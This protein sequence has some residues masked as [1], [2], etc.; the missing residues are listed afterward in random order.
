MEFG[1]ASASNLPMTYAGATTQPG[2]PAVLG[3]DLWEDMGEV[4][5]IENLNAW[6]S[7]LHREVLTLR[8]DLSATQAGVSGAFG[9]AQEAVRDLVT[10]FRIQVVAMRQT[11][12]H[13]AAQSL[14]NLEHVVEEARA[15][16][17]EQD[18]RFTLGLVEL[19][20]RLQAADTWAQAEPA[21]VAAIVHAAPAPPWLGAARPSTP[22]RAA[23]PPSLIHLSEPT[24]L[25]SISYAVVCVKKKTRDNDIV[26]NRADS[27]WSNKR[28]CN[29]CT[30]FR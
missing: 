4:A 19:A 14:A 3:P 11:T 30:I 28:M 24:R 15:R 2:G 8:A 22:P 10:A 12:M 17:G 6:G 7:G 1:V 25:L 9:Q 16:F 13:A 18:A 26:K 5:F 20:Q 23:P 29:Q 27:R 21:R